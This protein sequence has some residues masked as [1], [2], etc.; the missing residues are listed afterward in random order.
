MIVYVISDG[1]SKPDG[2]GHG[3]NFLP[4]DMITDGY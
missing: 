1:Y 4:T 3:Y 2:H